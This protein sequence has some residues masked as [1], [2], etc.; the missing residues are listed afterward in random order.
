MAAQIVEE[1]GRLKLV[2]D[3][4]S[5]IR[6]YGIVTGMGVIA[7]FLGIF[8]FFITGVFGLVFILVGLFFVVFGGQQLLRFLTIGE[9]STF[10]KQADSFSQNDKLLAKISELKGIQLQHYTRLNPKGQSYFHRY[11]IY[12][13]MP[14]GKQIEL[15]SYPDP[16]LAEQFATHIAAYI[17]LTVEHTEEIRREG[18]AQPTS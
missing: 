10:D 13:L 3:R 15:D 7:I 12:L 8:A 4:A 1:A 2:K 5:G 9:Y 11:F 14:D 17:G 16:A 18:A 6:N